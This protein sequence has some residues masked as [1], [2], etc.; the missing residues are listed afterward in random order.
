[1]PKG[2]HPEIDENPV[3]NASGHTLYMQLIG[4]MQCLIVIGRADIKFAIM[5]LSRFSACPR[6]AQLNACIRACSY[7]KMFPESSIRIDHRNLP[8]EIF[9]GVEEPD[10]CF[11][12]SYP[13]AFEEL[14]SMFPAGRGPELQTSVWFDSDHAHDTRTRH[15]CSGVIVFVGR[16]PVMWSSKRQPVIQASSY[17]AEFMAG[18][19]ATQQAISIR[20]ML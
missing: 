2:S 1:M 14:A 10:E 4:V 18:R 7:L 12:D 17:G 6:K 5:S 19:T 20:Y 9:E 11:K 16:T 3:L 13:D 8:G 15:S